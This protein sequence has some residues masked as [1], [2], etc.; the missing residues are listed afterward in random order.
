MTERS[1]WYQI[2][3]NKYVDR[4]IFM[5]FINRA[6][7]KSDG[8]RFFYASMGASHL[9]DHN[10]LYR[11]TG[12][13]RLYSFD[14]SETIIPRQIVN[15]PIGATICERLMSNELPDRMD[16]LYESYPT[17]TNSIV[18]LDFTEIDRYQQLQEL[19]ELLKISRGGD[20]IRL[21]LNSHTAN[22]GSVGDFRA[23]GHA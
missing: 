22:L 5:D 23:R 4:R 19:I 20:I 21:T 13:D 15:R 6:V 1:V 9:I 16:F 3:P 12:I 7:N 10:Q 14:G 17:A 2:R 11:L 18:W 8:R